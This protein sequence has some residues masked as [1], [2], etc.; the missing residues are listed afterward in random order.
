ML[1]R[2][3]RIL[4]ANENTFMNKGLC[5]VIMLQS[6]IRNVYLKNKTASNQSSHQE[7]RNFCLNILLATNK[8]YFLKL[9]IIKVY[10]SK[11]L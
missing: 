4:R 3:K 5:N 2:K 1:Q 7:A 9:K 6:K 10:D 11:K 8:E